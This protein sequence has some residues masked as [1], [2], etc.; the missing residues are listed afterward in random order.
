MLEKC[1]TESDILVHS[2]PKIRH[3]YLTYPQLN[4]NINRMYLQ[5]IKKYIPVR[6]SSIPL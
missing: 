1:A 3:Q 6:K 4:Y 5:S 2:Q